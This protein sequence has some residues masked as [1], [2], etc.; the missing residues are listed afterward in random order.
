[1][2]WPDTAA[3]A[4][5]V[6]DRHWSLVASLQ[7]AGPNDAV[8]TLNPQ[9]GTVIFGDGVQGARPAVGS[10]ISISYRYGAGSAGN[11]CKKIEHDRDLTKFWVVLHDSH[12]ALGWGNQVS[13]AWLGLSEANSR[14]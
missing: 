7:D 4:V 13:Q 2:Q 14:R 1:M 8:Y 9:T 3:V 12:Q 10:T 5:T 11:I 6:D